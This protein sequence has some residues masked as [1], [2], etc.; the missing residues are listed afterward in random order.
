MI[1]MTRKESLPA[2]VLKSLGL[3]F[4]DNGT[5]PIYTLSEVILCA[6]GREALYADIGHL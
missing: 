5:S 2:G 1:D 3:G 4:G 6:T